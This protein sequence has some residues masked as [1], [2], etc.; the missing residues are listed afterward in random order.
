M[1]I[2]GSVISNCKQSSIFGETQRPDLLSKINMF[3]SL[4]Q[5]HSRPHSSTD[6]YAKGEWN[7]HHQEP[8]LRSLSDIYAK[9]DDDPIKTRNIFVM[10]VN[11]ANINLFIR[12]RKAI[13]Y[14]SESF[15]DSLISL[16]VINSIMNLYNYKELNIDHSGIGSFY[17]RF[18]SR[19]HYETTAWCGPQWHGHLA[20]II[21]HIFRVSYHADIEKKGYLFSGVIDL[22]E[23]ACITFEKYAN[24][25]INFSF[26]QSKNIEKFYWKRAPS[27]W[28]HIIDQE[29]VKNDV[30]K[31]HL[32]NSQITSTL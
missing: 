25:I 5:E 18:Y 11:E 15:E 21:A 20:Q 16:T 13:F 3:N 12:V 31:M 17:V 22:V 23:E 9:M 6:T 1:I 27:Y 28:K 30:E 7:E 14:G 19:V 32:L 4:R 29:A 10:K 2:R 24:L 8:R 26:N